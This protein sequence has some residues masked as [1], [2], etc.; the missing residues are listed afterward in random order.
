[1]KPLWNRV[2]KRVNAPE[3]GPGRCHRPSFAATVEKMTYRELQ[4]ILDGM[5]TA[6]GAAEAHGWLCGALCVRADYGAPEWLPELAADS[7]GAGVPAGTSVPALGSLHEDTLEALSSPEFTF[8][9][10][11]PEDNAP[12]AE[13]VPALAAWCG[14]F[15]YGIGSG[16]V[17]DAVT[18][19]GDVA[20]L[21]EDLADITRAEVGPGGDR[22]R[23]EGDY[24]ELVEFVRAGAQLAFEETA[25]LRAVAPGVGAA[26]H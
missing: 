21:L 14:G 13:R 23:D 17:G 18:K 25:A 10:L 24:A 26:V 7:S 6:V 4:A 16:A 5:D 15:L 2:A 3:S 19:M 12:L 8:M 1:M 20:E 9:P 22:E 11:L